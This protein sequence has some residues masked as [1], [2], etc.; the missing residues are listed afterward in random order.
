MSQVSKFEQAL[1]AHMRASGK[2]ILD[3]IRQ[4]K[5]ITDD[6]RGK[7]RAELDSF[8]KTFA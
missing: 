4:E 1:L 8:S 7:L 5:Q 3:A 6:I 2:P